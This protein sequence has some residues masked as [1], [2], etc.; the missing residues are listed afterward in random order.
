[1]GTSLG[2]CNSSYI[3]YYFPPI[4][5][6]VYVGCKFWSFSGFLWSNNLPKMPLYTV[7]AKVGGSGAGFR[8]HH[9]GEFHDL[10]SIERV[11]DLSPVI[12]RPFAKW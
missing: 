11:H 5:P 8:S 12:K 7:R 2:F 3:S 10:K 1:M 6:A 4:L 9:A